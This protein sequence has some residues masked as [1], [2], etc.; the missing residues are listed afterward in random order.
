MNQQSKKWL[1]TTIEDQNNDNKIIRVSKSKIKRDAE[2]LKIL[3]NE[4]VNLG[5]NAL[6]HIPLDEDLLNA[7]KLAQKIKKKGYRRQIKLIGKILRHREVKSIQIALDKLKNRYN[8]QISLF[9]KL[10]T[11]CIRLITEG[12]NAILAVLVLYPHINRQ[13]LRSL[14]RNAQ[15]E[16]ITSKPTRALHQIFQYL[17][18]VSNKT[19]Q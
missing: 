11:L 16:K 6:E 8:Q 13:Q 7:I 10:E 2:I 18:K 3:G 9:K 17:L 1:D 19:L 15:K 12:D 5:K 14:V 4:L